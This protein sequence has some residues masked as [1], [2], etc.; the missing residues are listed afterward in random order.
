MKRRSA[1]HVIEGRSGY[2]QPMGL[3]NKGGK[4]DDYSI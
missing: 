2:A 3:R 1:G 4:L